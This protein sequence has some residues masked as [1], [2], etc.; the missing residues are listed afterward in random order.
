LK[1]CARFKKLRHTW[2]KAPELKISG[3]HLKK[4]A[5]LEICGILGKMRHIENNGQS[6]KMHPTW[7]NAAHFKKTAPHLEKCATLNKMR[8]IWKNVVHLQ[9]LGTF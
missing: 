7:K 1:K 8:H 5:N 6:W 3:P 9:L 2:K 4:S